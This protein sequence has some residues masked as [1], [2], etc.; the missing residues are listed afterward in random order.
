MMT[1]ILYRPELPNLKQDEVAGE[2]ALL[3]G[4]KVSIL[5]VAVISQTIF[6]DPYISGFQGWS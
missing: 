6:I 4:E 5:K 1:V 2:G 3:K